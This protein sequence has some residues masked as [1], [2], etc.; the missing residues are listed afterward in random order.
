MDGVIP[1]QFEK[2]MW[3]KLEVKPH[4]EQVEEESAQIKT[5]IK[6]IAREILGE[7]KK[8][9]NEWVIWWGVW[10]NLEAINVVS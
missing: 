10:I 1:I 8:M 5:A 3:E 2:E 4:K 6:K 7:V 9:G